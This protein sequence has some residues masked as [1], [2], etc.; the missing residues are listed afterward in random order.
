MS[1]DMQI[2]VIELQ[3]TITEI[4]NR[5]GLSFQ[6]K[7]RPSLMWIKKKLYWIFLSH[8]RSKILDVFDKKK[9]LKKVIEASLSE[10]QTVIDSELWLTVF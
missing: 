7:G 2:S 10:K 6:R 1:T 8:L 5:S 4:I 3:L 9:S